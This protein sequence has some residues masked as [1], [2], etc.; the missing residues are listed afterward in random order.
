MSDYDFS[1][2]DQNRNVSARDV[3]TLRWMAIEGFNSAP[4]LSP[5]ERRVG[6]ALIA[7]MDK[8]TR[9]CCPSA[10]RLAAELGVDIRSIKDA[11]AK[12]K[13][14]GLLSWKN[15]NGPRGKSIYAFNWQKLIGL[16][17]NAKDRGRDTVNRWRTND[18][19]SGETNTKNVVEHGGETITNAGDETATIRACGPGR[20]GGDFGKDGG[21]TS[22]HGGK[23]L[24]STVVTSP[25]DTT[26]YSTQE[27]L[28]SHNTTLERLCRAG[29]KNRPLMRSKRVIDN[30]P[31]ESTKRAFA[32]CPYPHLLKAFE[33]LPQ[34]R[35]TLL[36]MNSDDQMRASKVLATEGKEQAAA[37][38]RH[39]ITSASKLDST[40]FGPE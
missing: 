28:P 19:N 14:R 37:F 38:I 4:K 35:A 21:R 29:A 39:C 33:D 15:P 36:S 3:G 25:P 16:S 22:L 10:A 23:T 40:F 6:I 34:L 31:G 5:I 30:A 11:K 12:L 18:G 26:Q 20:I 7:A 9:L 13:Q 1:I 2:E 27:I 17:R 8:K 32:P 24:P